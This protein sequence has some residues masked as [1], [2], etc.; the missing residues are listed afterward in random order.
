MVI[1]MCVISRIL[2]EYMLVIWS[3]YPTP[4][5]MRVAGPTSQI[6]ATALYHDST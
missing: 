4:F 5:S 1:N 3:R 6:L 2:T